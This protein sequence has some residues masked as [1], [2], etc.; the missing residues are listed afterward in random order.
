MCPAS[1]G[2]VGAC[3]E[4]LLNKHYQDLTSKAQSLTSCN[5][6]RHACMKHAGVLSMVLCQRCSVTGAILFCQWCSVNGVCHLGSVYVFCPRCYP[7]LSVVFCLWCYVYVLTKVFCLKCYGNGIL[8][9]V[10]H[11]CNS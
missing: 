9:M 7:V 1:R 6:S 5:S 10:L 3:F 2:N 8:L 11:L 4:Y